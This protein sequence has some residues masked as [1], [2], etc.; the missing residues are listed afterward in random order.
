MTILQLLA[1]NL[2]QIEHLVFHSVDESGFHTVRQ[3][4]QLF[5]AEFRDS[6]PQQLS[7]LVE[8]IVGYGFEWGESDGN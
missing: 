5:N 1:A 4:L 3:A 6:S 2:A 7:N 8:Q